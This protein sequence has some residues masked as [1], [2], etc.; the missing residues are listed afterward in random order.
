MAGTITIG[1][2]PVHVYQRRFDSDDMAGALR[3]SHLY[4]ISRRPQLRL[5]AASLVWKP[6]GVRVDA[7]GRREGSGDI[8]RQKIVIPAP[9]GEPISD[10][11]LYAD[12]SYFSLRGSRGL[13]HGDAWSF[14][15]FFTNAAE[16]IAGQE[17]M[18]VGKAYGQDGSSNVWERTRKHETLSRIYEDHLSS[19]F[20]V[21]LTP[22][23]VEY[24]TLSS[25]DHINDNDDGPIL[26]GGFYGR[27]VE[28][29]TTRVLGPAIDLAEHALISH[30]VPH[31]NKNLREWCAASPT[32]DMQLM[33]SGGFRLLHVHFNGWWGLS[34]FYSRQ[35]PARVRSHLISHD[36][37][38][39]P[40]R[41][42]RRGIGSTDFDNWAAQLSLVE[43]G[44]QF[45]ANDAERAG[46]ALRV[47]G[48]SAP[49]ERRPPEVV[50]DL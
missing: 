23:E 10:F 49:G 2:R 20:D 9:E 40:S 39:N 42:V 30:F 6:Y 46:V 28:L 47:F 12:G 45:F 35:E 3:N 29:E 48:E 26:F 8:W 19:G 31:Y 44:H 34:R 16:E 4:L 43:K 27:Y 41:A 25:M 37:P 13:I 33:R 24:A 15:S 17:V 22:L 32:K 18:Y 1:V 14:A 36:L 5:D 50:F 7:Y 21:F 38:P 11:R